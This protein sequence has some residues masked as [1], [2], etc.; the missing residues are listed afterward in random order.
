MRAP[1]P[2]VSFS[3]CSALLFPLDYFSFVQLF[4]IPIRVTYPPV[5]TVSKIIDFAT[6]TLYYP[7][8]GVSEPTP[9]VRTNRILL[10][11]FLSVQGVSIFFART[12]IW[13]RSERWPMVRLPR[14]VKHLQLKRRETILYLLLVHPL[15]LGAVLKT[16]PILPT[17]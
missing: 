13:P 14:S 4:P 5:A 16:A 1:Q 15:G 12:F 17:P 6:I 7:A 10:H 3:Y 9:Y 8:R 2:V 11:G